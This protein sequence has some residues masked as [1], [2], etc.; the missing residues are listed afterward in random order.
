MEFAYT[1]TSNKAFDQV[2]RAVQ[3]AAAAQGLR[4]LHV[5]DVQKTFAEKGIARESY[6]IIEICN[7]KYANQALTGDPMIGLMMP[8]KVNVFT[9]QGKTRIALLL[10]SLLAEFYPHANLSGMASELETLLRGVV[11][12][13]K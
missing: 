10:P 7:V 9:E 2:E 12:C 4:V 11:D 13:A 5:H 6:K 1:V 8:C 3:D